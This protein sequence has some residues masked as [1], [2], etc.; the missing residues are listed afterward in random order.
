MALLRSSVTSS[1]DLLDQDVLSLES[2]EPAYSILLAPS[3][4]DE[5][6]V[7]EEGEDPAYEELLDVMACGTTRLR[8][9]LGVRER[10]SLVA[11]STSISCQAITALFL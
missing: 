1:S 11:D 10:K 7:V 9:V 8:S 5:V 2:C 4:Q 6:D 3:S